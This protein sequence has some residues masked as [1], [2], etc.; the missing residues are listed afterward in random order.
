M[1]IE[2]SLSFRDTLFA[3]ARNPAA[4]SGFSGSLGLRKI[5]QTER[6]GMTE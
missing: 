4:I 5:A 3:R 1:T 2:T 6:P